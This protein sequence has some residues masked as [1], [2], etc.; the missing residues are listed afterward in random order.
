MSEAVIIDF[1]DPVAG[2]ESAPEAGRVISGQPRT[3]VHN[4][5]AEPSGQF[6]AGD[7]GSSVGKWR[8]V[9]AEHEFCHL[10]EGKVVLTSDAGREW[11]FGP[12]DAWVIPAGFSGTWETL[13]PARKRYAIFEAAA[14]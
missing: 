1:R 8:V 3:V 9:Y 2:E 14:N 7:W 5:Y 13:E 12:G 11:R 4:R 10:L 6:F